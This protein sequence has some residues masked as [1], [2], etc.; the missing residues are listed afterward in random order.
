MVNMILRTFL[1]AFF[2]Q[3]VRSPLVMM[4]IGVGVG[5][6]FEHT[7][8]GTTAV[9]VHWATG[10]LGGALDAVNPLAGWLGTDPRPVQAS[11]WDTG[12]YKLR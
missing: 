3:V 4:V 5:M 6:Y 12:A 10:E 8:P 2:L 9:A 11:G 1:F 7:R